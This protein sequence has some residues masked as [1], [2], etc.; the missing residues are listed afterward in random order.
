MKFVSARYLIGL[1][2]LVV[3][4]QAAL[5]VSPIHY[6]TTAMSSSDLPRYTKLPLFAPHR[7]DFT[8]VYQEQHLTPVDPQADLW[9]QQ[10]L[11]LELDPNIYWEDKDWRKIYQLYQ[12]AAERNHWKAMLN[13]AGLILS[14][15]PVPVRD[16]EMA[17]RWVEKAMQLGV[18]DAWD[19]MGVY[20]MKGIVKG[21]SATSAYA[22]FQKAADMGSPSAQAFLGAALNAGWDNPGNGFW[23]NMPVAVKMLECSLGQGYGDAADELEFIYAAPH[24]PDANL[25]ALRVLHEGVKLGSAKCANSLAA[26]FSGFD[27]STGKNIAGYVDK[28]RSKRYRKIGDVLKWYEGTLKLPNLDKVLPLPPAAL[29]KWDGDAQTLIDA[30][31]AV[32]PPPASPTRSSQSEPHPALMKAGLLRQLADRPQPLRCDG[33]HKCPQ[34]GIWEARVAADHPLAALYNRWDRQAFVERGARFPEPRQQHLD[35]SAHEVSWTWLGSPNQLR[36]ADVYDI[37]L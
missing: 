29:P 12:Q 33:G 34:S 19:T 36:V 37:A 27:L 16:P 24:T 35:I 18:P 11:A 28:E 10:A 26:E 30:A 9:F 17:T 5:A 21:G 7:K 13:L 25:R 8:C 4:T 3:V 23:A 32:T 6:L 15:Y 20:H 31:K 22:F 1:C 14:D 2:L